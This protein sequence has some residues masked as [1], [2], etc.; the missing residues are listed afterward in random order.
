MFLC[1]PPDLELRLVRYNV[2]LSVLL[3][4]KILAIF[5]VALVALVALVLPRL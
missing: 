5:G 2:P 4:E 3:E 1:P